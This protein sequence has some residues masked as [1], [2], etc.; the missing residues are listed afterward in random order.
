MHIGRP[1]IFSQEYIIPYLGMQNAEA[2]NEDN[3]ETG[4]RTPQGSARDSG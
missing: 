1:D 4:T 2:I 3:G